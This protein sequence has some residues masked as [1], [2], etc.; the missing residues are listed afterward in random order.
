MKEITIDAKCVMIG[1]MPREGHE[2][3]TVVFRI[4]DEN[5]AHKKGL[6]PV[7]TL[8]FPNVEKVRIR[9]KLYST[10]YSEGNDLVINHLIELNLK[11]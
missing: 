1:R 2:F 9:G 8:E 4:F 6:L 10:Y 11:Y 3:K 7:D 5:N